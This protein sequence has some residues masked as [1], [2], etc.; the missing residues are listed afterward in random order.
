MAELGLTPTKKQGTA[1]QTG[2][3]SAFSSRHVCFQRVPAFEGGAQ[4]PEHV[5]ARMRDMLVMLLVNTKK[6]G[7]AEK[8]NAASD[9]L[10]PPLCLMLFLATSAKAPIPKP[11]ARPAEGEKSN[12]NDITSA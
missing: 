12:T 10:P 2:R 8:L 9:Y 5:V 6:E 1:S 4:N 3:R 11:T 7:T